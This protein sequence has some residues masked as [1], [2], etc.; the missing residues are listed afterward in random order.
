MTVLRYQQAA[1]E[2]LGQSVPARPAPQDR[3]EEES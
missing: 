3:R 2:L 1:A